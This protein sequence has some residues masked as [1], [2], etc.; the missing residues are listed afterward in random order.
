M[1]WHPPCT[2]EEPLRLNFKAV[3]YLFAVADE[4]S[5]LLNAILDD[6]PI[7]QHARELAVVL[8]Q[9]EDHMIAGVDNYDAHSQAFMEVGFTGGHFVV[10]DNDGVVTLEGFTVW[11]EKDEEED[12]SLQSKPL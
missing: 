3:S 5:R 10:D 6:K 2:K 1:D 7:A 8:R 11:S 12:E 9:L 4:A